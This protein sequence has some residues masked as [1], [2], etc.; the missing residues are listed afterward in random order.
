MTIADQ[1]GETPDSFVIVVN[2]LGQHALWQAELD[3]PRGWR[4][5]SP[6][7]SSSQCLEAVEGSWKDIAP[8]T[9][10]AAP[11][12]DGGMFVHE[13]FAD[14]A[15]RRP[16]ANAV[17]AGRT[18]M[19]YRELDESASRLAHHLAAAGVGP[20]TVTGVHLERGVD[21]ITA[22][23]A[24]MKAGGAYLPLDPAFPRERLAAIC[25]QVSPLAVITDVRA[26]WQGAGTRLLPLGELAADRP[27]TDPGTRPHPDNLC[28]VIYTSGSTGD[29]K[30]V[31]VSFGSMACVIGEMARE[32]QISDR[33]RVGQVAAMAFDTFLEQVFTALTAG[34]SLTLAPHGTMAPSEL[35]RGVERR[36]VTVLDLT[37]AYWHQ[38]LALT[39]PD[40]ERLRSVRLMITGGEM[41]DPA[42]C[43]AALHAAPWAR[44][45]NA[46]GLTETTITSAVFDIGAWLPVAEPDAAVPVGRPA[47]HARI[48]GLDGELNPVPAGTAGE[49]YIGGC[50]VARGYLGRPALTAERFLPDARGVAGGRMYRTGDLGRWLADG[51]LE[52]AGR[53]DRQLKVRGYRVE[54]GELER[55]LGGAPRLA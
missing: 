26:A 14:Q 48:M 5:N 52:V 43:R 30:A 16:D 45:L 3:V 49:I 13:R 10:R 4:R 17:V 19:T 41:A 12:A 42:D 1:S 53:V 37:P 55:V 29:P 9:A 38:V 46:Y 22:I 39:H 36:Q 47:G 27:V 24:I 35:L 11:G 23:L 50:G 21:L 44:L 40:D 6:V 54:P 7:M 51:S 28:Y 25:A 8:L 15:A 2:D 32:Y 31:A 20:E 34:A 18:R 33:D